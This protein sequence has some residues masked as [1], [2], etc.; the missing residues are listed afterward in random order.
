MAGDKDDQP[1][2]ILRQVHSLTLAE[3]TGA[4][5]ALGEGSPCREKHVSGRMR[6]ARPIGVASPICHL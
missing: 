4:C 5:C 2:N 1:K 3:M 6:Q